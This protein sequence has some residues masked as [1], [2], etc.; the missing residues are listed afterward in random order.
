MSQF[1]SLLTSAGLT[2]A[3][4]DVYLFLLEHGPHRAAALAKALHRP[5]GVAYKAL[6]DLVAMGIVQK[7][8]KK[9]TVAQFHA[10]HPSEL[11]KLFTDNAVRAQRATREFAAA[12]PDMV[13]QFNLSSQKPGVMF[14]EG[15]V[16]V[17][18]VINDNLKSRTPIYT[19]AD[20]EEVNKYIKDINA[21]Y[22]K[23]RDRLK[24]QKKVLLVDS[25]Y[26]QENLAS[27]AKRNLD[28]R[29]V[30]GAHSFATIM[31]IYDNRVAYVT[32]LPDTMFGIIIHDPAI[33]L[34]HKTLFESMWEHAVPYA[35]TLPV[36]KSA[37][38]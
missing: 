19:Y 25:P 28:V 38:A 22:A 10:L 24:L 26:T 32:L 15:L 7:K 36:P 8:D 16:G 17:K 14:Y 18:K 30:K 6:D 5:R 37:H 13:S 12:L 27:Y 2:Q 4:T 31:E 1:T 29:F 33:Y 23:K 35:S 9:G 11:E 21:D 20:M 3:Q 34:M